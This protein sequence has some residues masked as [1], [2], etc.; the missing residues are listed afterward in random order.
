[1][2]VTDAT[3]LAEAEPYGDC[4]THSRS[5]YEVWERWKALPATERV[6]LVIPDIILMHEYEE[7]PCGRIVYSKP[8]AAFW[9]Y[10]DR[11]LQGTKRVAKIIRRF[12][13]DGERWKVCSDAHYRL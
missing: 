6:R 11:R 13:L 3:P 9:V 7:F 10:A 12:G 5:H 8:E 2:L 1:M 4:L